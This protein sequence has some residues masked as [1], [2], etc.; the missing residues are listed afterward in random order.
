MG[1]QAKHLGG[2]KRAPFRG[3]LQHAR[4]RHAVGDPQFHGLRLQRLHPAA[5]IGPGHDQ[6]QAF[7]FASHLGE[8]LQQVVAALFFVDAAQEQQHPFALQHR[9]LINKALRQRCT[10]RRWAGGAVGGDR[11]FGAIQ[12]K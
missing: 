7:V 8:G 2:V 12:P 1:R 10:A 9:M 4:P 5:L 11:L 6:V 3:A